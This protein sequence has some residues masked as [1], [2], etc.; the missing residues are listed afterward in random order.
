MTSPLPP[1]LT[2]PALGQGM[3]TGPELR[4]DDRARIRS[5]AYTFRRFNVIWQF[6]DVGTR[7]TFRYLPLLHKD[8][9][10]VPSTPQRPKLIAHDSFSYRFTALYGV[11]TIGDNFLKHV[12]L[13]PWCEPVDA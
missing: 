1:H 8:D 13:V 4:L 9:R 7:L 6:T 10:T 12:L 2:F 3:M 5:K 11:L